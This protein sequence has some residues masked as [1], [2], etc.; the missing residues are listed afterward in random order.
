VKSN[1]VMRVL[2]LENEAIN[3]CWIAD[4]DRFSYEGLNSAERLQKPMIKFDGKWHETDW[5]TALAYVVKGLNGVSA[6]HGKDAIGFLTSP[7]STTEELYLAQKLARS[8]GVNNIDYRLRRSDF[9]A[10]AAQQGA[11]AVPA[12]SS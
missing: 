8:F 9:S 5:E 2:P 6:D 7:H 4:R 12:L 11:M 3:E 10:D 1:E